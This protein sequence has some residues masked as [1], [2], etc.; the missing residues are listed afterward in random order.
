MCNQCQLFYSGKLL[1]LQFPAK[2][3][4]FVGDF[5]MVCQSDGATAAGILGAGAGVV[6]IQPVLQVIGDAGIKGIV[7][8]AQ[9]IYH[10]LFFSKHIPPGSDLL[11]YYIRR[12]RKLQGGS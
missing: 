4:V 6:G 8:A 1:D 11:A 5:F 9:D 12:K 7:C 3:M 10:P 2:G